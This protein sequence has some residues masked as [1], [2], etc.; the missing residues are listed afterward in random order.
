MRVLFALLL[1]FKVSLLYGQD[2]IIEQSFII[3]SHYLDEDREY[4]VHIPKS[5]FDESYVPVAYP[6]VYL[7]DARAQFQVFTGIMNAMSSGANGNYRIPETIVVGI[8]NTDRM[9]DLTPT[10]GDV[11]ELG[12]EFA[13]SGGGAAF[14]NFLE[15]ELIPEIESRYRVLG[16]RTLVG[17]SLGGLLV[18]QA[19]IEKPE[20]FDGLMIIDP[21]LWWEEGQYL[22]LIESEYATAPQTDLAVYIVTPQYSNSNGQITTTARLHELLVAKQ[23]E[24]LRIELQRIPDESHA[25]VPLLAFYQGLQFLYGDMEID[26]MSMLDQGPS[27]V[28]ALYD[29]LSNNLG[30]VY[31]PPERLLEAIGQNLLGLPPEMREISTRFFEYATQVYPGSALAF[32]NLAE[33]YRDME[34]KEEAIQALGKAIE[35][36]SDNEEIRVK[37]EQLKLSLD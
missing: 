14:L 17:H 18:V 16:H 20:L 21:S 29:K 15:H 36:D 10:R 27:Y 4:W 33:S 1:V 5:Y 8:L 25:A 3:S 34:R 32:I 22:E 19:L 35:L 9:R 23:F 12:A 11:E 2:S 24:N 30:E 31:L 7:L 28:S 37:L 26:F 6:V 13:T